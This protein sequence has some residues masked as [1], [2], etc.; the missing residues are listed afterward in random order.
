MLDVD[1][2]ERFCKVLA[3][4]GL[5][6]FPTD[7]IWGIGCDATNAEA[8]EKIYKLKKRDRNKPLITIV[9][10]LGMLKEYVNHIHPK[11]E[12]LLHYHDR[13]LTVIYEKGTNLAENVLEK[14]GSA[15]IRLVKEPLCQWIISSYGK[16][17]VATSANIS[18]EVF[19]QN[20]GEI[21][22]DILEGVDYVIKAKQGEKTRHLPSQIVTLGEDGEL[23][24]IRD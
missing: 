13:P 9:D 10:S 24:F 8:V 6:L 15:A 3:V 4:G 5:I 2:Q 14:D 16:P 11:I 20:F 18:G 1:T 7:T 21:S 19:P 23:D 12:T 17:L 22:S